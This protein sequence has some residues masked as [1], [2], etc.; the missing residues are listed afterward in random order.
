MVEGS[1]GLSSPLRQPPYDQDDYDED[2]KHI[3]VTHGVAT[4]G[5]GFKRPPILFGPRSGNR[6]YYLLLFEEFFVELF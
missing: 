3:N 5:S 4:F 6:G 2:T 1:G